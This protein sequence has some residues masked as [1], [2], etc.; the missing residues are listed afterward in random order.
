MDSNN[1][2][3][4]KER[5]EFNKQKSMPTDDKENLCK[6]ERPEKFDPFEDMKP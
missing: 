6:V 1:K 4:Q 3:F 5:E 2:D